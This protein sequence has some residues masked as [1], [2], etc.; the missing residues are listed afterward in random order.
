MSREYDKGKVLRYWYTFRPA[1]KEYL[2][3]SN[4]AYIA[5]CC[6][7]EGSIVL[8]PYKVFEPLLVHM[9]TTVARDQLYW[10]VEI[11]KKAKKYLLN[12]WRKIYNS[13]G[14]TSHSLYVKILCD[15]SF[16]IFN[17]FKKFYY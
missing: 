14:K 6:G 4:A 9:K 2:Q 15:S 17:L 11:F 12:H 1:H 13:K 8:I 3:D 10:H 5:F 7:S 16:Y